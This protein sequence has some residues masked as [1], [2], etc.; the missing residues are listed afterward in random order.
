MGFF[1]SLYAAGMSLGPIIGGIIARQWGLSS[2]FILN[3]FL[4]LFGALFSFIKIP[5]AS[6][7][8]HEK[9]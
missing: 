1:Q 8:D 5:S 4:C 3:G 7:S 9:K 6:R 2:V